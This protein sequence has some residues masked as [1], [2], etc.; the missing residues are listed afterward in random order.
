MGAENVCGNLTGQKR[1]FTV[2]Q[3]HLDFRIVSET[4]SVAITIKYVGK[5]LM[6]NPL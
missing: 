1:I 3:D 2:P 4:A 5:A 6:T